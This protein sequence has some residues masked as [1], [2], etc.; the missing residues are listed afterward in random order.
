MKRESM[1]WEKISVDNTSERKWLKSKIYKE[2]IQP[3][4]KEKKI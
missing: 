1:A 2:L 4:S 3:Y